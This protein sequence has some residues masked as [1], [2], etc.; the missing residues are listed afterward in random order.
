M[1]A[2][3]VSLIFAQPII[4]VIEIDSGL[5]EAAIQENTAQSSN[6]QK[7]MDGETENYEALDIL[8]EAKKLK[9]NMN[10]MEKYK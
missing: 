8:A 9:L 4:K 1:K 3:F 10:Y 7:L 6:L 5:G 2:I